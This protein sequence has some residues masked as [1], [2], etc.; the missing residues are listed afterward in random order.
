MFATFSLH[1]R[2]VTAL[3]ILALA[4][5]LVATAALFHPGAVHTLLADGPDAMSHTF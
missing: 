3:L 5:K 2:I 4:G 1:Q